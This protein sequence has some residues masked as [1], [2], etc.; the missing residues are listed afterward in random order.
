MS[1]VGISLKIN[2]SMIEKARLFKGAKGMYLDCTTFVDL[3]ELDQ[4]GNSG[5]ITQDVTKEEKN[6][7]TKGPILG[8]SKVFWRGE[9][10]QESQSRP[11]QPAEDRGQPQAAVMDDFDDSSIPF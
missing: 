8:N 10:K 5:M 4:Y 6:S 9:G 11:H 1:K 7:G 3:D 2:V